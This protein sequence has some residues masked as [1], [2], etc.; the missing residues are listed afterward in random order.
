MSS[1]TVLRKQW[2]REQ[3]SVDELSRQQ[4]DRTIMADEKFLKFEALPIQLLL[5]SGY[6]V[7]TINPGVWRTIRT[8]AKDR[9]KGS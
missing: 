1:D 4:S 5:L 3:D 8:E 2:R 7:Y 9:P 6:F